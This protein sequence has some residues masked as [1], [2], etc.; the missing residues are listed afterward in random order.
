MYWLETLNNMGWYFCGVLPLFLRFKAAIAHQGSHAASLLARLIE[1]TCQY[2]K[3]IRLVWKLLKP[4]VSNQRFVPLLYRMWWCHVRKYLAMQKFASFETAR[5]VGPVSRV[6]GKRGSGTLN[7]AD[8]TD[9]YSFIVSPGDAVRASSD[10][11]L[12]GGRVKISFF[13]SNP[14]TG[15]VESAAGLNPNLKTRVARAGKSS[16][17]FNLNSDDTSQLPGPV[18]FFLRL[19]RSGSGNVKYQFNFK[20][21]AAAPTPTPTPTPTAAARSLMQ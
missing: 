11:T 13:F 18:T 14:Q 12:T 6:I 3:K 4:W 7:T 9:I 2:L 19:D 16:Q 21:A 15:Q 17:P 10:F 5:S 1:Q 20:R 8:K